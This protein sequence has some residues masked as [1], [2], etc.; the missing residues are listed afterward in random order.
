MKISRYRIRMIVL[1][2]AVALGGPQLSLRQANAEEAPPILI[3]LRN[4]LGASQ[5]LVYISWKPVDFAK[6]SRAGFSSVWIAIGPFL[7]LSAAAQTALLNSADQ[8]GLRS[9]GFIGGDPEWANPQ[10]PDLRAAAAAEYRRLAQVLTVYAQ[11]RYSRVRFT[12][13]VDVEPHTRSWWDGDLT[14]YSDLLERSI[15]PEVQQ[16]AAQ[17]P[18]YTTQPLLTRLEPFWWENGR[19]TESG[20][21]IRGLRDF[22]SVVASMTYRDVA[23]Q[24]TDVSQ[25]VRRRARQ[26]GALKLFLGV[27]TKPEGPGVPAYITFHG[28]L[29]RLPEEVVTSFGQMPVA[30]RALFGGVFIHSGRDEADGVLNALALPSAAE[31]TNAAEAVVQGRVTDNAGAPLAG[32]Q[33]RA[34]VIGSLERRPDALE[35][36]SS[37]SYYRGQTQYAVTDAGGNYSVKVW[38]PEGIAKKYLFAEMTAARMYGPPFYAMKRKF[39]SLAGTGAPRVIPL[40]LALPPVSSGFA[41]FV[42]GTFRDAESSKPLR[43]SSAQFT[44]RAGTCGPLNTGA[45]GTFFGVVP[46]GLADETVMTQPPY[47]PRV[48]AGGRDGDSALAYEYVESHAALASG[49]RSGAKYSLVFDLKRKNTSKQKAAVAGRVID[50]RTGKPVVNALVELDSGFGYAQ[51]VSYAVTDPFGY[52]E[53]NAAELFPSDTGG[54]NG[55]PSPAP[56]YAHLRTSGSFRSYEDP[57]SPFLA[58]DADILGRVREGEV[59]QRDFSMA[60]R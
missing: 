52:Y 5:D 41:A 21:T 6:A 46:L 58:Q 42:T 26:S 11:P 20:K 7:A 16:F 38:L 60:P 12:F 18:E 30:D 23:W 2:L 15:L 37:Y 4:Y 25:A 57:A 39:V 28:E 44:T 22:P 55:G 19:V 48:L 40:G 10:R 36:N 9:I 59:Y 31:D 32:V 33:V 13:V 3:P 51:R 27:E 1:L 35:I 49:M 14:A 45:E 29:E 47:Y 34:Q 50:A 53:I 43:A 8:A 56:T 54:I 17:F 24:I